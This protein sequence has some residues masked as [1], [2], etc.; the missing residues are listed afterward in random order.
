M[1]QKFTLVARILLGLVFTASAIA[2]L[3]GQ[4]PPPE[5]PEA[6]AF[7]GTLFSSGL[8][9]F[10][11]IIELLTGLALISGFFVPLALVM[12]APIIVNILYYHL[13]LDLA[14]RPNRQCVLAQLDLPLDPA[15]DG[16]VLGTGR[17][18][19]ISYILTG[20]CRIE[21]CIQGRGVDVLLLRQMISNDGLNVIPVVTQPCVG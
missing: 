11:K 16:Q 1:T 8:L 4:L 3:T 5:G 15:L 2:G 14:I 18:I 19:L 13:S 20:S 21:A 6:Q 10:V 17:D 7:M 12:L 9:V